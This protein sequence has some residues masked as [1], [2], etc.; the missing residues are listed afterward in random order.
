MISRYNHRQVPIGT[1]SAT[2]ATS[3]NLARRFRRYP[4]G[5]T[6][7]GLLFCLYNLAHTVP[8]PNNGSFG[9]VQFNE[10][11]TKYKVLEWR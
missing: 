3:D 10:Y 2:E 9:A 5:I 6:P 4:I 8:D 1:Y 11:V 7:L